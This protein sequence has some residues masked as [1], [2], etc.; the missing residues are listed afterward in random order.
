[1]E[2]AMGTVPRALISLVVA[3][4]DTAITAGTMLKVSILFIHPP[5]YSEPWHGMFTLVVLFGSLVL[6]PI[7]FSLCYRSLS[8]KK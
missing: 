4:V 2:E 8:R 1:M 3:S 5:D 6:S 7:L